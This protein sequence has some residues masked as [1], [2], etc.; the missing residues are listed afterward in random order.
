MMIRTYCSAVLAWLL[1]VG[2]LA[3]A[4]A[5]ASHHLQQRRGTG[6]ALR[7]QVAMLQVGVADGGGAAADGV[8][9]ATA[10]GLA[11][12]EHRD[13]ARVGGQRSGTALRHQ[14][15]KPRQSAA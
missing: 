8:R 1:A 3:V 11:G 4:A 12:E 9:R 14:A 7:R 10:R 13:K 6:G 5:N 15:R 2:W